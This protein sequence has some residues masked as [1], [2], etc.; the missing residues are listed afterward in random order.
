MDINVLWEKYSREK[1]QNIRQELIL[2]YL[3]LVKYTAGRLFINYKNNVEYDD[4]VSYG[5][6]GLID[7]IDKYDYSRGIK[8]DTYAQIRIRGAII[9][10]LREIDWIPRSVR[11]KA[12][13]IENAYIE[14][15]NEKGESATDDEVAAKLGITLSDFHKKI[16]SI[17]SYSIISLDEYLDQNREI[18]INSENLTIG[19]DSKIEKEE[20]K[21]ILADIINELP[22]KE[23]KIITLYYFEELTYKEIG[24][25]LQISE[26]RVSQLHTK[27]IIKL[28]SRLKNL[29]E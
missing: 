21:R 27:A 5:I 2:H 20:F 12:K 13:E 26:S 19:L 23:K 8:F 11:Q 22:E 9:D 16:Q 18:N 29:F 24:T 1:E 25:I 14:V 4:L 10:Y 28:K 7:A 17:S 15:E 6:F 3:Y